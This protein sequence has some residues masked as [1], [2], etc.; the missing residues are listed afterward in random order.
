LPY[1]LK[2]HP[3]PDTHSAEAARVGEELRDAR[4]ALGVSL[5]EM[6]DELRINRRYLAALEE[7]RVRD[8]PGIAYATGFVRS[9]AQI[10]GLDAPEMVRRFREGAG[11]AAPA[12]DLVF[13]EPVPDRGVPAGAV[14]ML[15]AVLAVVGYAGWYYWSG[16]ATRTAEEV[17]TLPPRLEQSAREAGLPPLPEVSRPA[18]T[19]PQPPA[20]APQSGQTA[21]AP[22]LPAAPN[23]ARPALPLQP[24]APA[25]GQ[26]AGATPN[27]G[28][29][30]PGQPLPS[31]PL[32]SQ[33]MPGQ[34]AP[35]QSTPAPAAPAPPPLAQPQ[36]PAATTNR[37]VLRANEESW[38]QIRDAQTGRS[39]LSRVLQAREVFEVPEGANLVMTTGKV[40]GLVIEV[41]GVPSAATNGLVGV[42]RNVLLDAARLREAA[43]GQLPTR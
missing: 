33:S 4:L 42:R 11:V 9:Y 6:A 1:D 28:Q 2:R 35:G 21:M 18:P 15:G 40:E 36:P 7:G 30:A 10:L 31:Q 19:T 16:S 5:E 25:P 29:P 39:V 24:G 27:T 41:D 32:P 17:P 3:R 38:V 14:I 8:L 43:A 13:P 22:A 34:S 20:A 37:I 23:A 12:K 26:P